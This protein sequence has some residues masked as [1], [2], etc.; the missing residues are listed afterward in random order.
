MPDKKPIHSSPQ[1][2]TLVDVAKDAG[3]SRATASLVLRDSPLVA[4]TTRQRVQDSMQRLGYV[5][6]RGA[7]KLRTQLSNSIGLVVTNIANPFYA[8]L[9]IGAEGELEQ[10]SYVALLANTSDTAS[11]QSRFFDTVLEHGVDGVLVCPA[12]ETTIEDL[13]R[14]S[15]QIPV[16]QFVRA[17]PDL[18]IDYVGSDNVG[19]MQMAVEHLIEHGHQRIAF[20][21]GPSQSSARQERLHGYISALTAQAIDVDESLIINTAVSREGGRHA[22]LDLVDLSNPPTAAVCYNDIIA[23]GVMVGLQ[24][25]GRVAGGDFAVIGFDDIEDATSSIPSLTT[26][27][28]D[29]KNIGRVAVNRLLDR[30]KKPDLEPTHILLESSLIVRES[31]GTH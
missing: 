1:R 10:S 11:K 20:I 13:E 17:L 21:G 24:S 19:G 31:C 16:V 4:D 23:F 7:A 12:K 2:I 9:T 26:I 5:Y 15:R 18:N 14:L 8:E 29:P 3:V 30:I 22:I 28:V 25:I 6:N 27:S